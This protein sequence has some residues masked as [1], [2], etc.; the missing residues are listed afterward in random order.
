MRVRTDRA[1]RRGGRSVPAAPAQAQQVRSAAGDERDG[2]SG[3]QQNRRPSGRL[4]GH[5]RGHGMRRRTGA[6]RRRQRPTAMTW[7]AGTSGW[8]SAWP[9][10]GRRSV[11]RSRRSRTAAKLAYWLPDARLAAVVQLVGPCGGGRYPQ[12]RAA[13]LLDVLDDVE[14]AAR[15]PRVGVVDVVGW[16]GMVPSRKGTVIVWPQPPGVMPLKRQTGA[17]VTPAGAGN[18]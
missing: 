11:P 3:H 6:E 14:A 18:G 10:P 16:A 7:P 17:M 4:A 9:A 13:R 2:E 12:G 15:V 5:W 8:A 1:T